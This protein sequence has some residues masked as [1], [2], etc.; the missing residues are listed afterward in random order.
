MAVIQRRDRDSNLSV[1]T[2]STPRR[3]SSYSGF[4]RLSSSASMEI[5]YCDIETTISS[6][7]RDRTS[8]SRGEFRIVAF[9]KGRSSL[10]RTD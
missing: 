4:L 1:V 2:L 6:G 10:S 5:V 3:L 9:L 8:D 7:F